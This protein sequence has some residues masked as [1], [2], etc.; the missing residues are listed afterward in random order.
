MRPNGS[1]ALQQEA[2]RNRKQPQ[3]A[4]QAPPRKTASW[5]S[6]HTQS[7]I[8]IIEQKLCGPTNT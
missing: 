1:L 5:L 2:A 3:A 4:F 6:H 7:F 8:A